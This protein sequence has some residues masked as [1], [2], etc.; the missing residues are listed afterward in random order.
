MSDSVQSPG[1]ARGHPSRIVAQTSDHYKVDLLCEHESDRN[2][3]VASFAPTFP[4]ASSRVEFDVS[5]GAARP[6]QLIQVC[7]MEVIVHDP[8]ANLSELV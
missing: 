5:V 7:F 4:G 2:E 6:L 3:Q 8:G 1:E